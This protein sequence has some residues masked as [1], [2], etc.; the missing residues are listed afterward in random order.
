MSLLLDTPVLLWWLADDPRL[1]TAARENIANP[2]N[3]VWIS[4][5]TGWEIAIKAGLGRLDLGEAPEICLPR[6]IGE[7]GFRTLAI[8]MRH[9]LAL[10]ALPRRH[11]DPFD[12][13]LI[14]QAI[15][16]GLQ[17]V[18][19]NREILA[20]GMAAMPAAE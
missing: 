8:T 15:A 19:D 5:A 9:A 20:Y 7:G 17:L 6:I 2:Q 12:R 14:V 13:M 16:E 11:A 1:G 4:A 3:D 10:G 18:T